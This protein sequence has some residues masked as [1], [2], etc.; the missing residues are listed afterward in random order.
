MPQIN[1]SSIT[2]SQIDSGENFESPENPLCYASSVVNGSANVSVI[3]PFHNNVYTDQT[4]QITASV[5]SDGNDVLILPKYNQNTPL[6]TV[7]TQVV[8]ISFQIDGL[9]IDGSETTINITVDEEG[10][11]E[12]TN[13]NRLG[14]PRRKTK[15]IVNSGG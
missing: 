10:L 4:P 1:Q 8:K 6:S 14:E 15:I 9:E 2:I 13:P 3:A 11:P 7:Y 12:P 5:S